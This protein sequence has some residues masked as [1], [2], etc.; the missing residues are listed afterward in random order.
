M[1]VQQIK[2]IGRVTEEQVHRTKP[3]I[4]L[5]QIA[6]SLRNGIR[7]WGAL[8]AGRSMNSMAGA[9]SSWTA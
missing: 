3:E 2:G 9:G 6:R 4:A 7:V 1:D 8:W 5:E